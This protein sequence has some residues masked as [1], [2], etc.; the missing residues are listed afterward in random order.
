MT[1]PND[2][3]AMARA[4]KSFHAT[5]AEDD[6][7]PPSDE[8]FVRAAVAFSMLTRMSENVDGLYVIAPNPD[9]VSR[10]HAI[11]SIAAN[12][13]DSPPSTKARAALFATALPDDYAQALQD[14]VAGNRR[15]LGLPPQPQGADAAVGPY[16]IA[17]AQGR[18]VDSL[19]PGNPDTPRLLREWKCLEALSKEEDAT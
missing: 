5:A 11:A 4:A 8:L 16:Q 15:A 2:I 13:A 10:A 6:A 9:G 12:F 1:E 18:F 3:I 17:E 7:P 14:A 19:A